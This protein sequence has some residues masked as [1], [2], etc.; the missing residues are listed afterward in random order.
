MSASTSSSSPSVQRLEQR[1]APFSSAKPDYWA[2]ANF[3]GRVSE[4]SG[5]GATAVLT[6]ASRLVREAQLQ[7]EPVAWITRTT[8]CFFPPD[9]AAN[10]IDLEALAVIRVADKQAV[11]RAADMLLRSGGFGLLVLDLGKDIHIPGPLQT[12]L[13]ALARTHAA[14]VLCLTQKPATA[15]SVGSL[16]ALHGVA[17][18]QHIAPERFAC[19]FSVVKDKRRGLSWTHVEVVHGPAGM[20]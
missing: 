4:F 2:W 1:Q 14:A 7:G 10:G 19:T 20:C 11:I 17:S 16:V 8:S 15:S 6:L 13:A 9:V 12:R 3:V 18:R 5:L